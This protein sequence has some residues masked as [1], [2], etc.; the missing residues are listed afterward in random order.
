MY[1]TRDDPGSAFLWGVSRVVPDL[2]VKGGR[3]A[4][5]RVGPPRGPWVSKPDRGSRYVQTIF[6]TQ[7][8]C[9]RRRA[10]WGVYQTLYMHGLAV[11]RD[12]SLGADRL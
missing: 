12:V 5:F 3:V 8:G 2:G 7:P 6:S 10:A 4:R 1:I 11:L 9:A